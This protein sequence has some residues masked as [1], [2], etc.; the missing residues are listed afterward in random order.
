MTSDDKCPGVGRMGVRQLADSDGR[1]IVTP[2]S[3]LSS[4]CPR[5]R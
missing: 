3:D 2:V 5:T 1:M 4:R